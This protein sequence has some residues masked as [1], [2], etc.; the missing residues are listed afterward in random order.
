[1]RRK[2]DARV[3][4]MNAPSKFSVS[5]PWR[6]R[7]YSISSDVLPQFI[8][9]LDS[10]AILSAAFVTY[11]LTEGVYTDRT[12]YFI[13]AAVFVWLVGLLLMNIAGLYK[14]EPILRPAGFLEKFVVAFVTTFLFL[15]AAAFLLKISAIYSRVWTVSFAMAAFFGTLIARLVAARLLKLVGGRQLFTRNVV[16]CG[17]GPQARRLLQHIGRVRPQFVSL[18]GLFTDLEATKSECSQCPIL[19]GV[20]D[21]V[22]Y[23]RENE[24]DDIVIALPW[25]ADEQIAALV[26]KLRVLPVNVY[27]GADLIGFSVALRQPPDHFGNLPIMEIM[28][29]PLSGWGALLKATEDY[30]LGFLFAVAL[31]PVMLLIALAIKL[32]SRGPV[33]FRQKRY[34]F[35]NTTFHIL[36]FRTMKHT[37][38]SATKTEQAVRN[39]PRVTRV[40]RFLRRWSLDEIPQIFN[41]LSGSMSL[42][43]PRPHAIDHDE[44]YAQKIRGYFARHRVKPGI[45]GWAQVNGLRGQTDT[46]D[47]M[48]RR[49]QYDI[50]YVENW[51]LLFDL[52]ILALTGYALLSGRNA[53]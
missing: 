48:E 10:I 25:S 27:L 43:G 39:D 9:A 12:D 14:F 28:G 15:F 3:R 22:T 18:V 29:R 23:A 50:S 46:V 20:D 19:G 11:V 45:T 16:I 49:V 17:N 38:I 41:V 53:Y 1:M 40:G 6:R 37:P 7:K 42:V 24:V 47:K 34:G 30:V 52:R 5:I 32:D 21:V 8:V 26:A 4:N 31:S 13:F 33:L 36:K 44:E 2:P 51:S 35:V